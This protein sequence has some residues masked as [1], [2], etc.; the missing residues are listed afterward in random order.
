MIQL[1]IVVPVYNVER[2]IRQCL[3]SIRNQF[4]K[5]WEC[6]LVDDGTPDIC[7]AICDEYSNLDER[8]KVFHKP[9][10]GVSSARNLG[11]EYAKGNWVTFIDSDDLIE[12]SYFDNIF[13]N[14][15]QLK[16]VDFVQSGATYYENGEKNEIV[17]NYEYKYSNDPAFLFNKFRGLTFSK[18][19]R[20]DILK[21]NNIRFDEKIRVSEDFIFTLD[22]IHFVDKYLFI[23]EYGYLYRIDNMQSVMHSNLNIP[24][25]ERYYTANRMLENLIRYKKKNNISDSAIVGR[26]NLIA[27][28]YLN[29]FVVLVSEIDSFLQFNVK[30]KELVNDDIRVLFKTKRS[31]KMNFYHRLLVFLILSNQYRE[32]Y[33]T[34]KVKSWFHLK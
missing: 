29:A 17:Q 33:F 32:F 9:N 25:M 18:L 4:Y 31:S 28:Y 24:Y 19:F 7:G 6:I 2:Y 1:T 10:G 20:T 12:S 30:L 26:I 23:P 11:I 3:D 34:V 14:I 16:G 15:R 27:I 13:K 22:Y 8:F 5:D 21:N